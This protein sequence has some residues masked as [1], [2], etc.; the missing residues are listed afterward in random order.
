[1]YTSVKVVVKQ[2]HAVTPEQHILAE[3]HSVDPQDTSRIRLV[4]LGSSPSTLFLEDLVVGF[5]VQR[6]EE[7]S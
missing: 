6:V 2:Q 1:M 3:R 4:Q 5:Q 7:T